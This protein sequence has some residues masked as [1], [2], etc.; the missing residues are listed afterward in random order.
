M[1][2][3]VRTFIEDKSFVADMDD[4]YNILAKLFIFF[5]K[6]SAALKN[7]AL[8]Y[9]SLGKS[10]RNAIECVKQLIK[11]GF[12]TNNVKFLQSK[13]TEFNLDDSEQTWKRF[14]EVAEYESGYGNKNSL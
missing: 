10:D 12:I 13:I 14:N 9:E 11:L 7:S 5:D 8:Q 4:I 3:D 2:I 6:H 1:K